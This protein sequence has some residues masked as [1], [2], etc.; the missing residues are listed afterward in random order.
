MKGIAVLTLLS[1][2]IQLISSLLSASSEVQVQFQSQGNAKERVKGGILTTLQTSQGSHTN[3]GVVSQQ[4]S[5][6]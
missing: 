4:L 6:I 3:S 1:P 2:S 5:A